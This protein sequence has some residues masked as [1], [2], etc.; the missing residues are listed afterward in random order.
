[1]LLAGCG[2]SDAEKAFVADANAVCQEGR[3]RIAAVAATKAGD[4]LATTMR[5]GVRVARRTLKG[6]RAI[7]VPPGLVVDMERAYDA[8]E[9][10][11]VLTQQAAA[12]AERQDFEAMRKHLRMVLDVGK[13]AGEIAD[14]HGLV[15]CADHSHDVGPTHG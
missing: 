4:S 14:R 3:G 8:L 2:Q 5:R 9:R 1:M 12:A 10:Q 13:I 11:I 15:E 7:E 6:L